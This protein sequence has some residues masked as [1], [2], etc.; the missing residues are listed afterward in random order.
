MQFQFTFKHMDASVALE[1]YTRS[2]LLEKIEK[3]V[4]KPIKASVTY[5]VD[6][7]NHTAHCSFAGGDGFS[8]EVEHTT[9]DMYASVDKLALKLEAQLKRQ[10]EKLKDHKP[11]TTLRDLTVVEEISPDDP[12]SV[13]VDASDIVKFELAKAAKG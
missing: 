13:P 8:F 7:H 4:T 9:K 2:K 1:D 12:E 5:A 3:F 11:K 10:K 6:R